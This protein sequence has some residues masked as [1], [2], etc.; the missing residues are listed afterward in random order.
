M[1]KE[2]VHT[3]LAELEGLLK[4]L[5]GIED[6]LSEIIALKLEAMRRADVEGMIATT[7]A[8][9][10]LMADLGRLDAQRIDRVGALCK[11]LGLNV[12]ATIRRLSLRTLSERLE[13][14]ARTR[15]L[16]L[17]DTLREKM[18]AVAQLNKV[19][20]TASREILAHFKTLFSAMV[21]DDVDKL[22]YS[23]AGGVDRANA[24]RVLDA[25]G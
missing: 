24:A 22:T 10:Q 13:P 25:M 3:T 15:L 17:A 11:A 8:E 23:A 9:A 5:I 12:G 21:Q 6:Q 20:E 19:V 14:A 2:A 7:H 1:S 4:A 16:K 18:L